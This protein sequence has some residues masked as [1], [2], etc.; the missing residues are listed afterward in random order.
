MQ[1]TNDRVHSDDALTFERENRAKDTM[2]RRMLRPH[3][4]GQPLTAGVVDFANFSHVS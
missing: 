2:G 4:H 1:V 3:V